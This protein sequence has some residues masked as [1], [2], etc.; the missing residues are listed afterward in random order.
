VISKPDSASGQVAG[1]ALV[2]RELRRS[3]EEAGLSRNDLASRVG[4]SRTYGQD[5]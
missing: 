3:R 5:G 1:Q 2:A 4:Y